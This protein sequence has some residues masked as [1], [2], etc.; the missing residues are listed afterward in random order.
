MASVLASVPSYSGS[1]KSLT[2]DA[3]CNMDRAGYDFTF[4]GVSGYGVAHARNKMALAA[5]GGGFDWLLMIDSD[6]VP[7]K[8]G[9]AKLVSHDLD[10]CMGW[11]VRG[12]SNDGK[13]SVIKI[14]TRGFQASYYAEELEAMDGL[15]QVKGNGFTFALIKTDVLKT[16]R[17]PIFEF[18]ERPDNTQLGEDYGFCKRCSD[19]GIKIY[20]DTD[21]RC[22][23]IHDRIL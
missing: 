17:R 8:D 23:H 20:V 3:L 1:V 5:I 2:T 19:L 13:T 22:G 18:I 6:A 10:V 16:L 7:P 14:G 21:V 9:F 11:S 4:A 15:L 12:S